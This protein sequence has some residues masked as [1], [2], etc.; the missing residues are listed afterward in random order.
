L[1]VVTA[2]AMSLVFQVD[3][4]GE[5]HAVIRTN[6]DDTGGCYGVSHPLL[7]EDLL[8][9]PRRILRLRLTKSSRCCRGTAISL[10]VHQVQ[11]HA[12]VGVCQVVAMVRPHSGVVGPK[13]DL[14][15]LAGA[16]VERVEP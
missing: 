3:E 12:G 13:R 14:P 5:G 2:A 16:H 4:H 6:A 9:F 1:S 11:H 15:D 8:R 10:R 7:Y